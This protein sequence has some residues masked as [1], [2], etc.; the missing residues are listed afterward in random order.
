MKRKLASWGGYSY[1]DQKGR[2]SGP[3]GIACTKADGVLTSLR[4]EGRPLLEKLRSLEGGV[5]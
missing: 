2:I 4:R 1:E 5:I 3:D